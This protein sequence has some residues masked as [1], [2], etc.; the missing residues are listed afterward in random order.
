M[1]RVEVMLPR[2]LRE[3]AGGASQ[4]PA[5]GS[6]VG[7]V[8]DELVDRHP[9]LRPTLYTSEGRLRNFVGVFRNDEDVRGLEREATPVADGDAI[10]IVRSIAGG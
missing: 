8:L 6:T 9:A 2:P 1:S 5:H 4:V 7:E 3:F 10:T